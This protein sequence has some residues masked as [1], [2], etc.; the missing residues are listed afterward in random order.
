MSL[1]CTLTTINLSG[2][3]YS[4]SFWWPSV[5]VFILYYQIHFDC[6]RFGSWWWF[7]FSTL[8]PKCSCHDHTFQRCLVD[9][10]HE[11]CFRPVHYS[12][13][14]QVPVSNFYDWSPDENWKQA[15][16]YQTKSVCLK[17]RIGC[18]GTWCIICPTI[19]IKYCWYFWYDTYDICLFRYNKLPIDT[20]SDIVNLACSPYWLLFLFRKAIMFLSVC[21]S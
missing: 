6:K 11:T 12:K 13:Q 5:L 16:K 3:W 20:N 17:C 2:K 10:I 7:S 8:L 18:W 14:S 1:C 9:Y 19:L 4:W 15:F 21:S